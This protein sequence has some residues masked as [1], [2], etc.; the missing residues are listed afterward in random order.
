MQ[1]ILAVTTLIVLFIFSI[2]L[3]LVKKNEKSSLLKL[4]LLDE[5][6]LSYININN[7]FI[8]H[9]TNYVTKDLFE[10]KNALEKIKDGE[11][12]WNYLFNQRFNKVLSSYAS[13]NREIYYRYKTTRN[14]FFSHLSKIIEKFIY[15]YE[16]SNI[17]ERDFSSDSFYKKFYTGVYKPNFEALNFT[18]INSNL[19]KKEPL[20]SLD[21]QFLS[22][23]KID[24]YFL[25]DNEVINSKNEEEL[26]MI[27]GKIKS[28]YLEWK[29][30]YDIYYRDLRAIDIEDR[31]YLLTRNAISTNLISDL[32]NFIKNRDRNSQK[33][34]H[35]SFFHS[36]IS[37]IPSSSEFK[38]FNEARN[39][40]Y[41]FKN[42]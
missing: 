20:L 28:N 38:Y 31:N 39:N 23:C 42:I 18:E 14:I 6:I 19:N 29:G 10:I 1:N 5:E 3:Y 16:S 41:N 22:L 9:S 2:L 36:Q 17:K 40:F 13:K 35:I 32:E 4:K 26:R 27:E 12:Q 8:E 33:S 30:H 15:N 37:S 24:T 34:Y 25:L 11:N 21:N 7:F